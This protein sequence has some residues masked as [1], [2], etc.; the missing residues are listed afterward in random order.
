MP[1]FKIGHGGFEPVNVNMPGSVKRNTG[2]SSLRRGMTRRIPKECRTRLANRGGVWHSHR[3]DVRGD[4]AEQS[5]EDRLGK[6]GCRDDIRPRDADHERNAW[7]QEAV[8]ARL[9]RLL[10]G[11]AT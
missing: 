5:D 8:V 7:R 11:P 10:R 2:T 1:G 3:V 4:G 6:H 9:N